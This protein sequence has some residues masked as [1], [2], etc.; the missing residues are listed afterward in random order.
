MKVMLPEFPVEGG[1]SC[2]AI[3]YR[4]DASP[5]AVYRCHCTRCQAYSGGAFGMGMPVRKEHFTVLRGA[6]QIYAAPADSGREVPVFFCGAC[7][8]RVWH[9]PAH[10]PHLI[11]AMPGTLDDT[12]WLVSVGNFWARSKQAGVEIEPGLVNYATQPAD[13]QAMYDAW[14]KAVDG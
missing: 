11:N 10:S 4:M 6:P 2:G 8:T 7:G 14:T 5:L 12:S 9:A 13:R 3:R 1:C